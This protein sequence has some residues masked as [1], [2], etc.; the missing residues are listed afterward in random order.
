MA[1]RGTGVARVAAVLALLVGTSGCG[2]L[3]DGAYDLP[4]PGGA[5][6]GDDP[7]TITIEFD[8]VQGLVPKSTVKVDNVAVGQ[9]TDIAVDQTTWT[10]TVTAEVRGDL[11]LPANAEARVRRSSLLGEWYV[12]LDDPTGEPSS[13]AL[14]S[15]GTIP[16]AQTGGTAPVEQVL[17]ALSLLLNNG[18]LP[19]LNTI[20][21]ELNLALDGNEPE[22][23]ALLGDLDELVGLLDANRGDIV[24]ALDALGELSRTL[25]ANRDDIAS[26]LDEIPAGLEVLADQRPQLVQMLRSLDRLSDVTVRVVERSKDDVVADLTQLEPILA[27]LREAGQDLPDALQILAT[28]PFTPGAMEAIRGDYVNLNARVELDLPA[29]LG[30]LLGTSGLPPEAL[31]GLGLGGLGGLDGLDGLGGLGGLGLDGLPPILPPLLDGPDSAAGGG[32]GGE[33]GRGPGGRGDRTPSGG[34]AAPPSGGVPSLLDS[35]LGGLS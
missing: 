12:E 5:D 4:L 26:A 6:V 22:V 1:A 7:D 17:G 25:E 10:A 35:L 20:L 30:T 11:D 33:G 21:T 8:S 18:G 3:S 27:R 32:G 13:V 31:D 14:A 9:V 15:T 19:Q 29:V 23:R 2:L 28:F 24:A 16:M 34:P